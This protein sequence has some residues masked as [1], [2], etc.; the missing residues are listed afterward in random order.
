[1][2]L[3]IR[4]EFTELINACSLLKNGAEANAMDSDARTP[5]L[6]AARYGNEAVVRLLLGCKG[7]DVDSKDKNDQTPLSWAARNGH[8]TVICLLLEHD[9]VKPDFRDMDGQ[10][11][12]SWAAEKFWA[13]LSMP[14]YVFCF[15]YFK[16]GGKLGAHI[17]WHLPTILSELPQHCS[18][19]RCALFGTVGAVDIDVQ[20][21]RQLLASLPAEIHVYQLE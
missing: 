4:S 21:L 15:S 16:P 1:M 14:K 5:L 10:T 3:L 13:K 11:P 9:D 8:E 19:E 2:C 6:W 18:A 17:R 20:F 12:L 7:I